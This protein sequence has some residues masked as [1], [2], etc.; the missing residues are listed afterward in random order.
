MDWVSV[1]IPSSSIKNIHVRLS[2]IY[3][4]LLDSIQPI[5]NLVRSI[6]L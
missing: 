3:I 1:N 2:W 4:I 6:S 5:L